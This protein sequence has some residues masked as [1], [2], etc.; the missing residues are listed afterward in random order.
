MSRHVV[1]QDNATLP[2]LA[3]RASVPHDRLNGG[4]SVPDRRNGRDLLVL[5]AWHSCI[6]THWRS[7]ALR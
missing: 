5:C 7:A 3:S 1:T 2:A 6:N 4:A